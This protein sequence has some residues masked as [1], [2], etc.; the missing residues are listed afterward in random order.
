MFPQDHP[1]G[2]MGLSDFTDAKDLGVTVGGEPLSHRLYHFR[3][4]RV[5]RLVKSLSFTLKAM[6]HAE[7]NDGTGMN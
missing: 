6:P 5:P 1:P 7:N 3:C 2:R 4:I